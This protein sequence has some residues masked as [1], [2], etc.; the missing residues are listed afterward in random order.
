MVCSMP[1]EATSRPRF[2][3]TP[4]VILFLQLSLQ[5]SARRPQPKPTSR[6]A[7]VMDTPLSNSS[8]RLMQM[9]I[10]GQQPACPTRVLS[11]PIFIPRG[12][13]RRHLQRSRN[14]AG[15]GSS[16]SAAVHQIFASGVYQSEGLMIRSSRFSIRRYHSGNLFLRLWLQGHKASSS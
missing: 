16:E 4:M 8:A 9:R 14:Q 7:S 15:E 10:R 2:A 6:A 11:V 3:H 13:G 1:F 5:S 12:V